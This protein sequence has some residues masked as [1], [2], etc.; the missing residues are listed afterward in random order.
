MMEA[1]KESLPPK[2]PAIKDGYRPSEMEKE[3]VNPPHGGSGETKLDNGG[4][5]FPQMY[6]YAVC[7]ECGHIQ[8]KAAKGMSLRD[9]FA[10]MALQALDSRFKYKP[11]EIADT[12]YQIAD[13]M[14]KEQNK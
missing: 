6:T 7:A 13:A 14:I 4:P 11:K 3:D 2:A 1:K 12:V 9:W 8:E 5:A 10:G